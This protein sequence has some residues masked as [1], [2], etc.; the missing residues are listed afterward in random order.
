[1][2]LSNIPFNLQFGSYAN[3]RDPNYA[4]LQQMLGSSRADQWAEWDIE[5]AESEREQENW[6]AEFGAAEEKWDEEYSLLQEQFAASEETAALA[7]EESQLNINN[8]TAMYAALSGKY[9]EMFS[10]TD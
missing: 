5:E 1:M 3:F 8:L 9:E 10:S 6:E 7:R 2:A 4:Q